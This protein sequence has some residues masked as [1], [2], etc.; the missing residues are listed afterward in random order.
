MS[1]GTID[2]DD[3]Y[4]SNV[5]YAKSYVVG[6]WGKA[7]VCAVGTC[8]QAGMPCDQIKQDTMVEEDT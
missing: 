6:G 2:H 1:K 4:M 5:L 3:D 7:L 8:T